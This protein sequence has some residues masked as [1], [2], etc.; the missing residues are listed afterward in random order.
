MK[1][2][3]EDVK[4]YLKIA[5]GSII[6]ALS[7]H[8]FL[9]PGNIAAGG[10]S[11]LSI[12]LANVFPVLSTAVYFLILN[13][14]LFAV[15]FI[16]LGKAFG[17]KTIF[18]SVILT[19]ALNLMEIIIPKAMVTDDIFLNTFFGTLIAAMAMTI[20]FNENASTGGTDIIAKIL[21]KYFHVNIGKALLVVDLIVTAFGFATFGAR[22]GLYSI[23]SVLMNGVMIDRLLLGIK[24]A[25]EIMIMSKKDAEIRDFIIKELDRSCTVISGKGGYTDEDVRVLYVVLNRTDFIRLKQFIKAVDIK[26]FISVNEVNEILGEGY[27]DINLL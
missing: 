9:I 6:L 14:V 27:D 7:L 23:F 3:I 26:A 19:I 12:I 8:F 16:V 2:T 22:I 21:N 5:A 20:V 24:S 18:S 25:N 10:V 15:G 13:I 4:S 17:A 1:L 11:G